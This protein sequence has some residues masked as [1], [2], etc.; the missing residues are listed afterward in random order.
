MESILLKVEYV[1][2][3]YLKFRLMALIYL[4][5]KGKQITQV[6]DV[7]FLMSLSTIFGVNCHCLVYP[8][9]S[10]LLTSQPQP[11][12]GKLLPKNETGESLTLC[13]Y[14]CCSVI[15]MEIHNASG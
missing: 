12:V 10:V 15:Q 1:L 14:F 2:C 5:S 8:L 6:N 9:F 3:I 4:C 13:T 7:I 11:R